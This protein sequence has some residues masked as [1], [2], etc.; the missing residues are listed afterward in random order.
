MSAN[1]CVMKN[2]ALL[3]FILVEI[4]LLCLVFVVARFC[5]ESVPRELHKYLPAGEL[6]F[7]LEENQDECVGR[8][9]SVRLHFQTQSDPELSE[10]QKAMVDLRNR[11]RYDWICAEVPEGVYRFRLDFYRWGEDEDDPQIPRIREMSVSG[12][13]VSPSALQGFVTSAGKFPFAGYWFDTT[14]RLSWWQLDLPIA[15][16]CWVVLSAL[17]W[18]LSS[19]KVGK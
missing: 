14:R 10:R 7:R 1:N 19:V 4:E 15:L 3:H 16:A 5:S 9:V 17:L 6:K 12:H 11:N 8:I 2:R 13:D 18:K